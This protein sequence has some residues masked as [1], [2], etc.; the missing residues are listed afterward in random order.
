VNKGA[1]TGAEVDNLTAVTDVL[2]ND[3][4]EGYVW[5][6]IHVTDRPNDIM[7]QHRSQVVTVARIPGEDYQCFR[8]TLKV[9][10]SNKA[11]RVFKCDGN[12]SSLL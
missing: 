10:G 12:S 3:P 1:S 9:F 11:T 6:S 4:V 2:R 5:H 7:K 8:C